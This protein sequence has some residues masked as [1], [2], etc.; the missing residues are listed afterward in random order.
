VTKKE[1]IIE[2]L[3]ECAEELKHVPSYDEFLK[4]TKISKY[5]VRRKFGSY[6]QLLGEAGLNPAGQGHLVEMEPL[7]QDWAGIVRKL[8]KVP[9][10]AEYDMHSRFSVRPLTRRFS[11]WTAIAP[12]MREYIQEQST[13]VECHDVLDVIAE[14][15]RAQAGRAP[16][17]KDTLRYTGKP[18][19]KPEE[20][21]CGPP[22]I[23]GPMVYAPVNENGVLVLFGA[24]A[25]ELGFSILQVQQGFPDIVAMREIEP[26]RWQRVRIE[27]EYLSRSFISHMHSI[28]GCEL[29]VCWENNWPDCPLEVIELKQILMD[30]QKSCQR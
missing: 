23:A 26:G 14:H 25:R 27:V 1:D 7:F 21:V 5:H 28:S 12:G 13:E 17:F 2:A 11:S 29:I 4:A 9:T 20:P 10:I 16:I 15:L 24:L 8:N 22:L 30:A 6:T 3:K 19:F 18:T